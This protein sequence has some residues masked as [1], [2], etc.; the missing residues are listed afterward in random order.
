MHRHFLSPLFQLSG[1]LLRPG[2]RVL[3]VGC[4]NGYTAGQFAAHG[5]NVIGI[6]LS[7]SGL[8]I[9][10]ANYPNVRFEMLPADDQ[11]LANLNVEPFDIVTSTEVIEHLYDPEAFSRGCYNS[12]RPRGR[13]IVSTPY[14]GYLK[15]IA[16]TVTNKFDRHVNPLWKGGTH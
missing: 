7:E 11:I 12:L 5:C 14:H 8:A 3:D 16:L 1:S 2:A 15:N 9:G 6:D 10:R 4:G 13:L